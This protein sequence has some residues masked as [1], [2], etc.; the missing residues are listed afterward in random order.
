L[1]ADCADAAD[2]SKYKTRVARLLCINSR[3]FE[4]QSFW[5]GSAG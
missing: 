1:T 3:M 5:F 4:M 2:G